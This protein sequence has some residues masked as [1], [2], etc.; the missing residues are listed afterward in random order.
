MNLLSENNIGELVEL[1]NITRKLVIQGKTEVF[2]VYRIRLD[3]IR[4]NPQND[5]IATYISKY[6]T[7]HQGSLPDAE[8]LEAFNNVVE[9]FII[10]SNEEAIKK[11]TKNIKMFGQREPGVVLSNGLLID[12]NRR[13][14]CLRKLARE[15]ENFNWIEAAILPEDIANDARGI[16]LLEL[17]I[18]HGEEGRVDYNPIEKLVGVYNDIMKNRLLTPEEYSKY[19]DTPIPKVK[20]DM[21]YA[22]YMVEFL[23]FLNCPEQF[24][25]ARELEIDGPIKE[26]PAILKRCDTPDEEEQVKQCVFANIV[27]GP[28]GDMTRFIRKFKSILKTPSQKYLFLEKEKRNTAEVIDLLAT[29][30][31]ISVSTIRDTVRSDIELIQR[32]EKTMEE[33]ENRVKGESIKHLPIDEINTASD[34]LDKVDSS[35][36]AQMD[37]AQKDQAINMLES[38]KSRADDLIAALKTS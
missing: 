19:T 24:H 29:T 20:K 35:I 18:Q 13:F 33:A 12:G 36:F 16:K 8:D 2:P 14:T 25:I 11:T 38:I 28:S 37:G 1:T 5:R 4:Y 30:D 15:D 10:N 34:A 17:S 21:E 7:E 3:A 23:D 26:M 6:K 32:F 27:V 31:D 22:R 9:E